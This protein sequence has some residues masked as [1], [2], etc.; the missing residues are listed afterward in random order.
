MD[1]DILAETWPSEKRGNRPFVGYDNGKSAARV[2]DG[3]VP[4][5]VHVFGMGDG[6]KSGFSENETRVDD[7]RNVKRRGG[8]AVVL[9]YINAGFDHWFRKYQILG[10]FSNHYFGQT[11]IELP[12]HLKSREAVRESKSGV[13]AR[14]FFTKN[15]CFTNEEL[16]LLNHVGLIV[17]VLHVSNTLDR[18]SMFAELPGLKVEEEPISEGGGKK[19]Q[20]GTTAAPP[21]TVADL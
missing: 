8:S 4:M 20:F 21:T 5:G 10:D 7:G 6:P 3:V 12:Y 9:H 14:R 2:Q 1:Q 16:S 13:M 19:N 17:R 15:L 18:L 11:P